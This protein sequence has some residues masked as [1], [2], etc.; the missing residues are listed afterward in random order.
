LL[1]YV[2]QRI[3]T[4]NNY[5]DA[6]KQVFFTEKQE[7]EIISIF[8]KNKKDDDTIPVTDVEFLFF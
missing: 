4:R 8:Q 1:D 5:D 3:Y 7:A 2:K 6:N